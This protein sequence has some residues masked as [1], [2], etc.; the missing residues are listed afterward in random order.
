MGVGLAYIVFEYCTQSH[1]S[2]EDY[3]RAMKGL[4]HTRW[5]KKHTLFIRIIPDVVINWGKLIWHKITRGSSRRGRRSLVWTATCKE[6]PPV[7]DA[8]KGSGLHMQGT[9]EQWRNIFS[10]S[11]HRSTSGLSSSMSPSRNPAQQSS[12]MLHSRA[13]LEKG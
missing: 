2:T 1:L 6:T 5:F 8:L 12:A 11:Q 3:D 13:D 10:G 7:I 4:K 9:E